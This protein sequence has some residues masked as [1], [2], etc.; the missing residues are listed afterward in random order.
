MLL[1]ACYFQM[2]FIKKSLSFYTKNR[3]MDRVWPRCG[4]SLSREWSV[5][6]KIKQKCSLGWCS[7][8]KFGSWVQLSQVLET[9]V[10]AGVGPFQNS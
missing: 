4:I 8:L 9:W 2:Y 10:E 7:G 5:V 3:E 6:D 1:K